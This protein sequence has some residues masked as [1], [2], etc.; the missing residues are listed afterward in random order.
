MKD[1]ARAAL[2]TAKAK[3]ATY[4]DARVVHTLTETIATKNGEVGEIERGEELGIGVRVIANGAWG[5]A[6][7]SDLTKEEVARAASQA[8]LIAKA[9]A[10]VHKKDVVLAP[11]EAF[12]ARWATPY[13]IDP[14]SVPLSKKVDLLLATDKELRREKAVKVA[15]AY[16]HFRKRNQTFASTEGSLIEQEILI[17]GVGCEARAITDDDMQTRCYPNSF[18]G[19][20]QTRGYE[21]VHEWNLPA[22]APRVAAE[23]AALLT[24]PRCPSGT[25][26]LIIDG[27]QCGLQIHESCGHPTEL[28][29]VFGSEANFAGTSFL[30]VDKLKEKFRYG[31]PA[32]NLTADA[33]APFGLGTFGYDDEGVPAQRWDLVKEGIFTGYL[34]S[35]E[36][37]PMIGLKRSQGAMRA[38]S[39]SH[40]PLIRMVNVSLQPGEWEP[41][42]L[43][44]DTKHGIYMETNRSWSIDDKRYNF[45]FGTE[46]G[47]L[48][49]NGKK[50]KLVKNPTYQGITPEFWGSCDATCGPRHWT[51]W[52]TPNCG[53][54]QPEQAMTTGHGA[55][56]TRFRS[57]K[58]GVV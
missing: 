4:A 23:A 5:F 21:L 31:S 2:D 39:F 29:R 18:R 43:I 52:G 51:L 1:L 10:T 13:L 56:P 46:V 36:T 30:T 38:E 44:A 55:A 9:S 35:R 6:A 49:E 19:Q 3:G 41:E 26:D 54:G 12:V 7:T 15:E 40:I 45:Q 25:M 24:A 34:T 48:I 28:D 17:S 53:K 58:V 27:S 37:A 11:E 20:Y 16:L 22:N 14:F 50:T 57:V 42:A 33:T 47:W 32:V 8:V